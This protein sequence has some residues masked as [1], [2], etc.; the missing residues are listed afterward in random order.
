[1]KG[2][3]DPYAWPYATIYDYHPLRLCPLRPGLIKSHVHRRAA[4]RASERD[5]WLTLTEEEKGA[6]DGN[7]RSSHRARHMD[8]PILSCIANAIVTIQGFNIPILSL[9]ASVNHKV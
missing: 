9:P 4:L 7:H 6:K 1:M 2:W 3:D 5:F 8:H